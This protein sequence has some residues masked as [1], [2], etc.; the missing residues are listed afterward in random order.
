MRRTSVLGTGIIGI[1]VLCDHRPWSGVQADPPRFV[2][3]RVKRRTN[4]SNDGAATVGAARRRTMWSVAGKRSE[5]D[6]ADQ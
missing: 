3:L 4:G 5:A 6:D 1:D 2:K